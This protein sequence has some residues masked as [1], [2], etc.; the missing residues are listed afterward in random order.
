VVVGEPGHLQHGRRP[1]CSPSPAW[2]GR[3]T[4]LGWS[5]R[6][7]GRPSTGCPRWCRVGLD[8]VVELSLA[9]QRAMA[10]QR[11]LGADAHQH[12][13]VPQPRW[14]EQ[15]VAVGDGQAGLGR[16]HRKAG[17]FGD[18]LRGQ[19]PAPQIAGF[20]CP[21]PPPR[22]TAGAGV[23]VPD[24]QAVPLQRYIVSLRHP[25][26]VLLGLVRD[27]LFI[28][29]HHPQRQVPG[30]LRRRVGHLQGHIQDG[31][32]VFATGEGHR[33][34]VEPAEHLG[35]PLAGQG[36]HV[37]VEAHL[38]QGQFR[39]SQ[40]PEP[41]SP[42]GTVTALAPPRGR[43]QGRCSTQLAAASLP[44]RQGDLSGFGTGTPARTAVPRRRAR[45]RSR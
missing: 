34:V 1:G 15:P 33:N 6:R 4:R 36:V 26:H 43:S 31:R 42:R 35:G 21:R 27:G 37:L 39:L 17:Q 3:S 22:R 28:E 38:L 7:R 18:R 19:R 29:V 41:P 14:G 32:A 9:Q 5:S 16:P 11:L 10:G 8:Q 45:R 44:G 25:A 40:H 12:R 20:R 13:H 23:A 24:G 2:R 30:E